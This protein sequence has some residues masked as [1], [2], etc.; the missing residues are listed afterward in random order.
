MISLVDSKN[1]PVLGRKSLS[2]R[3]LPFYGRA[4]LNGP[5]LVG[6]NMGILRELPYKSAWNL[7]VGVIYAPL[8]TNSSPPKIGKV[9]QRKLHLP[10]FKAEL[11]GNIMIP[12]RGAM[13]KIGNFWSFE[14]FVPPS[15]EE[16]LTHWFRLL[17]TDL[18]CY[19]LLF[20]FLFLLLLFFFFFSSFFLLFLLL[21]VEPSPKT[22]MKSQTCSRN[23]D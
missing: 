17:A 16:F 21:L 12:E 9:P 23:L 7:V 15:M 19:C 18:S 10:L 6:S 1:P 5:I 13:K 20:F 2:R 11:V 3:N 22:P 4:S 14:V 8:K